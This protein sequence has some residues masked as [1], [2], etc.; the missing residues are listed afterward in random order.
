MF[1]TFVEEGEEVVFGLTHNI[2]TFNP[3]SIQFKALV[4]V[5]RRAWSYPRLSD[6]LATFW[7]GPGWAPGKPRL[8][9][10]EDIPDVHAPGKPFDTKLPAAVKL[11]LV[12]QLT[13]TVVPT[14]VLIFTAGKSP[15]FVAYCALTFVVVTLFN[16]GLVSNLSAVAFAAETTR[17]LVC[18]ALSAYWILARST[19]ALPYVLAKSLTSTPNIPNAILMLFHLL[20]LIAFIALT[21]EP[22]Q[23]VAAALLDSPSKALRSAQRLYTDFSPSP[24]FELNPALPFPPVFYIFLLPSL[25]KRQAYPRTPA[26]EVSRLHVSMNDIASPSG[27]L[28]SRPKQMLM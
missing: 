6:K 2:N 20:S 15:S 17:L 28:R 22:G 23:S 16:I 12:I 18:V 9:L 7:K 8:G 4:D 5:F 24:R 25:V 10:I 26:S 13:S 3:I 1:G 11:Y 21:S 27:R 19:V 14:L